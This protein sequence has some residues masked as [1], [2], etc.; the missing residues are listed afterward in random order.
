[1]GARSKPVVVF[2]RLADSS[3]QPDEAL[4]SSCAGLKPQA[5]ELVQR[6][7]GSRTLADKQLASEL[8][9]W[10]RLPHNTSRYVTHMRVV[11]AMWY[12]VCADLG[13]QQLRAHQRQRWQ[14]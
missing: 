12:A 14:M 2:N 7:A 3:G 11:S 5:D 4:C 13:W 10:K 8:G 1:V 9:A 6:L